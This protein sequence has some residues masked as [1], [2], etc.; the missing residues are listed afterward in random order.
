ML[1]NPH[2]DFDIHNTTDP[3][4]KCYQLSKLEIEFEVM[5]KMYKAL[6]MCMC[7]KKTNFEAKTTKL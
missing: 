5:E 2:L 4:R 7:A 1:M 3:H 6:Y